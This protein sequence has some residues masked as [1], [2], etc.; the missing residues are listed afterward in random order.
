MPPVELVGGTIQREVIIIY[1]QF[2]IWHYN[3]VGFVHI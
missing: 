3:L 1:F 2:R